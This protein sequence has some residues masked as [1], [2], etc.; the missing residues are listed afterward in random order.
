MFEKKP[1]FGPEHFSAGSVIIQQ[2]DAPDNF[3]IITRGYVDVLYQPPN[4]LDEVI[5][6]LGPGDYFGEVGMLRRSRRMATVKAHTDVDVMSMDYQTFKNWVESSP[7]VAAEIDAVVERRLQGFEAPPEPL[8]EEAEKEFV[9][10]SPSAANETPEA[11]VD[12]IEHFHKGEVIVQAGEPAD[13]FY[14]IIEGFVA[15]SQ[16]QPD[17]RELIINQ[18]TSGDY[19]GE[20]GLLDGGP[21]LATVTALTDVKALC[22]DRETF[23][24]WMSK[25]PD[26]KGE[27]EKEAA[28]RRKNTGPL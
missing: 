9:P 8:P 20:I 26:I 11:T 5:D 25:S 21:R 3:Y 27:L 22:F 14:I 1:K 18:Q 23:K 7:V 19:F 6:Q 16:V 4:G 28:R 13:K 15:V 10:I 2:G 24:N 17:G 12:N